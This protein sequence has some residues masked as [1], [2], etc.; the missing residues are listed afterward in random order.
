MPDS[1]KEQASRDK[2][3]KWKKGASGNPGAA[4]KQLN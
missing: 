1:T 2:G 4:A 3:G